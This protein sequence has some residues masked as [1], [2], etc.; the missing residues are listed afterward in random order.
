VSF[1]EE[2]KI[3]GHVTFFK[4]VIPK[5]SPVFYKLGLAV[6]RGKEKDSVYYTVKLNGRYA[7]WAEKMLP[8]LK[9]GR[10]V[11]ATGLPDYETFQ[12][13]DGTQRVER[14]LYP[15]GIPELLDRGS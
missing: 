2:L 9:A 6:D 14:V 3:I 7:E 12:V 5:D 1:R 13:S 15:A 8:Y 10:L 11:G 4:K